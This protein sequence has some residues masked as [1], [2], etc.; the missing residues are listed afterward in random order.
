MDKHVVLAQ[1]DTICMEFL[2]QLYSVVDD[3]G[4]ISLL[5]PFLYLDGDRSHLVVGGILHAKLY[6]TA[7]SLQCHLDS[8]EIGIAVV[9]VGDELESAM[10]E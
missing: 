3:E 5:A 9:E 8:I 10:M 4:G 1:V 2:H 7:S 6:P